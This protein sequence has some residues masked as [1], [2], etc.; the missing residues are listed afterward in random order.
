MTR[1]QVA[2]VQCLPHLI[3]EQS[4]RHVV[5]AV[6]DA[7]HIHEV[8]Q[9]VQRFVVADLSNWYLDVA[10]DRLYVRA[11][12]SADRRAC[13]TVMHAL[14]QARRPPCP[15]LQPAAGAGFCPLSGALRMYDE[16]LSTTLLTRSK[17]IQ[18]VAMSRA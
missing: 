17:T 5:A 7:Y 11:A 15:P 4:S 8:W 12:E 16:E 6:C 3:P 18:R 14:L 13:Q 10:K 2:K 1:S 9:A